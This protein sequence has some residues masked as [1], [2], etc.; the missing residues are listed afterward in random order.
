MFGES[1]SIQYY[2]HN[3]STQIY[4]YINSINA[5]KA[6][7]H[8][9]AGLKH[10]GYNDKS[11]ELFSIIIYCIYIPVCSTTSMFIEG[12]MFHYDLQI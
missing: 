3:I 5:K 12:F 8:I 6:H 10:I 4:I 9:W 2:L 7:I 1:C 11:R